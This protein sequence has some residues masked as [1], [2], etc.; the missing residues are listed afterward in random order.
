[1]KLKNIISMVCFLFLVFS[2]SMDDETVMNDMQNQLEKE[3]VSDG[4]ALLSFNIGS[5]DL[6]TRSGVEGDPETNG[7]RINSCSMI[8]YAGN[9]ILFAQDNLKSMPS[10]IEGNQ[11]M[12][13]PE[14]SVVDEISMKAKQIRVLTKKRKDLSVMIVANTTLPLS[15]RTAYPDMQAIN[16]AIEDLYEKGIDGTDLLK[17]GSAVID[18]ENKTANPKFEASTGTAVIDNETTTNIYMYKRLQLHS[19]LLLFV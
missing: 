12:P 17:V 19:V 15:N 13:F 1:M 11:I 5:T 4:N 14:G 8:L 3:N 7:Q 10:Q 18:F 16:S 6:A 9:E 2:C